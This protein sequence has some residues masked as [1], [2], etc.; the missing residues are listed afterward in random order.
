MKEEIFKKREDEI[1]EE[2]LARVYRS[3][4]ELGLTNKE[5]ANRINEELG[6]SYG[7]ST[8]RCKAELVNKI[9]DRQ[10][11]KSCDLSKT[12][13]DEVR[14]ALGELDIKEQLVRNRTNKL[15]KIKRDFVKSLEIANDIKDVLI[16]ET[17]MPQINGERIELSSDNKLIVHC[18]D[19]HIGYVINGYLNN[20]YNYEIAKKRLGKL[21]EEIRKVCKLYNINEI[22]LVNCGD[23]IENTYM[24]QNQSYE[25]EFDLSHQIVYAT[26]LLYSFSTELSQLDGGKNINIVSVGGNHNRL[27]SQKDSNIEGDEANVIVVEML[28]DFKELSNNNRITIN[29]T[30][31]KDNSSEFEING[32][33]FKAIHGDNR[34]DK[35]KKLYDSEHTITDSKY[36]AIFRGHDHNFN[37]L[38]QNNGGYVIT[39]GCLFGYNPYSVKKIGCSTNA[40]QTL[41]VVGQ[42][43]IELIKDVNLQIN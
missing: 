17:N 16:S 37:V 18:G 14:E 5:I 23:I 13:L 3:K 41:V 20:F 35:N 29:D 33:V 21:K 42:E 1:F 10:L 24:R 15:N 12:K 34:V 26:K 2:Y 40:S 27:N 39:C 25:C 9:L 36:K 22:T 4:I 30:D 8:L 43:D 31:Y 19:W 7:E 11:E 38:S 32:M 6:T 28:K